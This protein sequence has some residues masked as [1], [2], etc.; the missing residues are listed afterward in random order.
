[1]E[2][3]S[4]GPGVASVV[5]TRNP[6][7]SAA[8]STLITPALSLSSPGTPG[9]APGGEQQSHYWSCVRLVTSHN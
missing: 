2:D 9:P 8:P 5:Q 3:N 7:I 6:L 4:T 1:M